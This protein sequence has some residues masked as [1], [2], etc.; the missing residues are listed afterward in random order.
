MQLNGE[1]CAVTFGIN[2]SDNFYKIPKKNCIKKILNEMNGN[3][4]KLPKPRHLQNPVAPTYFTAET[5]YKFEK[6]HKV[7]NVIC[8][9]LCFDNFYS[10]SA[11]II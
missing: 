1:Q 8:S 6:G 4:A 9:N 2:L 5:L 10:C 11:V 3:S 7:L